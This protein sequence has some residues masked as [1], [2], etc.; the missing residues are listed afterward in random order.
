MSLNPMARDL[1]KREIVPFDTI[2]LLLEVLPL[3]NRPVHGYPVRPLDA[4][5]PTMEVWKEG[6]DS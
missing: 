5:K 2:A 4:K 6:Q 3:T 1:A